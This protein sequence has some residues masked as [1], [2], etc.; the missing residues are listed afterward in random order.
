MALDQVQCFTCLQGPSNLADLIPI[1]REKC[2][3]IVDALEKHFWFKE[4]D[5]EDQQLCRLCW[6]QIDKFHQFYLAIEDLHRVRKSADHDY[7][8]DLVSPETDV[9]YLEDYLDEGIVQNGTYENVFTETDEDLKIKIDIDK[10]NL[11]EESKEIKQESDERSKLSQKES[12][13]KIIPVTVTRERKHRVVVNKKPN[14]KL[15][16]FLLQDQYIRKHV[17]Y[18]CNQCGDNAETFVNFVKHARLEHGVASPYLMC[19]GNKFYNKSRLYQHVQA[20]NDPDT[21]RCEQCKKNFSDNEGIKRHMREFHATEDERAFKCDRCPKSFVTEYK[22]S[23][24]LKDHEDQE[25]NALDCKY[26]G[27]SY[28]SRLTLNN[29]IKFKHTQPI[30]FVCE[31]C[32]KGFHGFTAFMEHKLLHKDPSE[33]KMQCEICH[34]WLKTR[35]IWKRHVARHEDVECTCEICGH[36]SPNKQAMKAHKIRQHSKGERIFQCRHCPKVFRQAA[37][38]KDHE[39]SVHSGDVLNRCLFC[40]KRFNSRA[41]MHAHQKKMHPI[42]WSEHHRKRFYSK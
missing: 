14:K 26:C 41:N 37:N 25:H 21:F 31:I 23:V 11:K 32:A 4:N 17:Q 40:D 27:T 19:C 12:T 38:L 10:T 6:V 13:K 20:F 30:E 16:A 34:K 24:H 5:F 35:A 9:E 33:L 42:E 15:Q 2:E 7:S 8:P 39:A 18:I 1:E 36:V 3:N 22:L 29:H 28:K